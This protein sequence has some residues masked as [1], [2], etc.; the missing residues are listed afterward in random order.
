MGKG[1]AK[2]NKNLSI[3]FIIYMLHAVEISLTCSQMFVIDNNQQY[4][5][6]QPSFLETAPVI[7]SSSVSLIDYDSYKLIPFQHTIDHPSVGEQDQITD[8]L[9]EIDSSS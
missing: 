2:L 7:D 5:D 4:I 1:V 9:R 3:L 6:D 8:T